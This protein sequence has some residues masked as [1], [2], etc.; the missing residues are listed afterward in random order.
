MHRRWLSVV[1][2]L[3][4]TGCTYAQNTNAARKA[5]DDEKPP[6]EALTWAEYDP[7]G[8]HPFKTWLHPQPENVSTACAW[9]LSVAQWQQDLLVPRDSAA[10]FDNCAFDAAIAFVADRL[11][12]A[13]KAVR[14][15][16]H[17]DAMSALGQALH[18]IQDFYSHSSYV[19]MMVARHPAKPD[20][21]EQVDV[22]TRDG[23]R[24]LQELVR[25][26]LVSGVVSYSS[27]DSKR[28]R[29]GSPPHEVLAKDAP[30]FNARAALRIPNWGNRT[31]HTAALDFAT[32]ASQRFLAYAF[33]RWPELGRS[34]GR[35]VGYLTL[36]ERRKPE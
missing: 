8:S 4:L 34:C 1:A 6:L 33:Q 22:W 25:E 3:L 15:G 14:A 29:A 20:E 16:E 19:E 26:G 31:H 2:A 17:T 24:N 27:A 9:Q 35:P 12:A 18:A 13:D 10:H 30:Q 11:Q 36:T 21:A 23:V 28:C 5:A 32:A 7:S